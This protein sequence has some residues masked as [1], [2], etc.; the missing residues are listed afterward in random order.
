MWNEDEPLG[1]TAIFG[2]PAM[3][4]VG[5]ILLH[6]LPS[7]VL[8]FLTVWVLASFPIGILIG[9]CALSEE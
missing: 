6:F 5:I 1:S 2:P 3:L 4:V 8:T 7:E 9:H